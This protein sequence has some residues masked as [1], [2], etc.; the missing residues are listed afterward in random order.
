MVH[1]AFDYIPP[2]LVFLVVTNGSAAPPAHVR[3]AV[4][5]YY[6]AGDAEL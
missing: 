1:P 3:R 5:E 2:E 4:A 6:D